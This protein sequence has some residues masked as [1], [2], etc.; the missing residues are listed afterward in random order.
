MR[1]MPRKEAGEE[2]LSERRREGSALAS[3]PPL[4]RR[5]EAWEDPPPPSPRSFQKVRQRE[6]CK[7]PGEEKQ[8]EKHE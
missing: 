3:F 2:G 8:K 1:K 6:N 5:G 4:P 7:V